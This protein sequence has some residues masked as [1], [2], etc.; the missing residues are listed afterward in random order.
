MRIS[1]NVEQTVT[2]SIPRGTICNRCGEPYSPYDENIHPF[3][4]SLGYSENVGSD[5]CETCIT[6][7]IKTFKIVPTG[8]M[9]NLPCYESTYDTDHELHQRLF[10][11]WKLTGIWNW[12]DENPYKEYMPNKED[13]YEDDNTLQTDPPS[14][15]IV[16]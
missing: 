14:L 5:L 11:E 1:E 4:S 7:I 8:F 10:D 15:S 9:S 6:N 2:V 12:P 16:K 13:T 3:N